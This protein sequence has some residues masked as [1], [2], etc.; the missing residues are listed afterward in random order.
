LVAPPGLLADAF[1]DRYGIERGLG[2]GD[3]ASVYLAPDLCHNRHAAL[4]VLRPERGALL[5]P[6]RFLREIRVTAHLQHPGVRAGP[7]LTRKE[8]L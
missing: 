6:E 4:K 8:W 5:G 1:R 7:L 2:R 3:M